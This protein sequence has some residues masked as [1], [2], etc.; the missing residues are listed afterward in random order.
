[1]TPEGVLYVY[2]VRLLTKTSMGRAGQG[3]TF[4]SEFVGTTPHCYAPT[5]NVYCPQELHMHDGGSQSLQTHITSEN[6]LV[7]NKIWL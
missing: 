3:I 7:L 6:C 2:Q 4:S 1:M 5:D